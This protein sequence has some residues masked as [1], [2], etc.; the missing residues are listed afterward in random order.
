MDG[1]FDYAVSIHATDIDGDGDTDP[2]N[3][4]VLGKV[5]IY[6]ATEMSIG[7]TNL[8]EITSWDLVL[9]QT[10]QSAALHFRYL[11]HSQ[12]WLTFCCTMSQGEQGWQAERALTRTKTV[13]LDLTTLRPDLPRICSST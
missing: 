5:I 13:V 4:P 1:D 7:N 2:S 9:M 12:Y 6:C 10:R 11:F 8:E 3:T